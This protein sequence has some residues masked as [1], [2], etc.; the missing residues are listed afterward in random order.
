MWSKLDEDKEVLRKQQV[1]KQLK[2]EAK[3][4]RKEHRRQ[5]LEWNMEVTCG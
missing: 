3:A 4:R 5:D 1:Q 2:K